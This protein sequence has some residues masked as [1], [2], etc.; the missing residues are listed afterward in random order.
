MRGWLLVPLCL[1]GWSWDESPYEEG[2]QDGY[3]YARPSAI[4]PVT[5]IAP[6]QRIGESEND[7]YLRGAFDG[8]DDRSRGPL[9]CR[10]CDGPEW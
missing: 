1:L 7:Y 6:Q 10:V 4:N 9:P 2:Y 3:T 8:M 5:P